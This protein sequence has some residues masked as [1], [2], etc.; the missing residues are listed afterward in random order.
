MLFEYLSANL[1]VVGNTLCYIHRCEGFAELVL[2]I[3]GIELAHRY[4]KPFRAYYAATLGRSPL[5]LEYGLT[6][7]S[8]VRLRSELSVQLSTTISF[9][10]VYKALLVGD[11][12]QL[13][14]ANKDFQPKYRNG[15]RPVEI[16]DAD[17][18]VDPQ[19]LC[20]EDEQAL[21][22]AVLA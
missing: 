18:E 19:F 13:L 1:D 4:A 9:E 3:Q 16:S 14:P 21:E 5:W 7:Q 10:T 2:E 22:I 11:G 17:F 20:F 15:L 6:Q 12:R 8:K